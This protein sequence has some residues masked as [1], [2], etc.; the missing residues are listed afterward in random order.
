MY[1]FTFERPDS[2]KATANLLAK[3]EEAKL[4]A[5]GQT[6]IPTMKLRLASPA[7]L[8]DLSGIRELKGIEVTPRLVSIGAMTTH[9]EVASSQAVREAIPAL[10]DLAGLIGDP[11]V[12]HMGTIGGS[13]ANN[14][15]AADYPAAC[16]GLAATIHTTK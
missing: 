5:G 11:A 15:P 7:S 14:D 6:L 2:L 16:L 3:S 1:A 4:L 12:R 9:A 13:V 8:I 10:A